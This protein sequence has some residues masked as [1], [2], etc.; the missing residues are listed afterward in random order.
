MRY[1]PEAATVLANQT[2]LP[3]E[4]LFMDNRSTDGSPQYV[5]RIAPY[6][7]FLVCI[8]HEPRRGISPVCNLGTREAQQEWITYLDSDD[9]WFPQKLQRKRS[10]LRLIRKPISRL[11]MF[12]TLIQMDAR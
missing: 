1:L 4:W 2:R 10:I 11:P 9:L 3:A 8:V 6:L 5:G 7:P 12:G